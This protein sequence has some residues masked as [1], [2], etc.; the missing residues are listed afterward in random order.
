MRQPFLFSSKNFNN[1][2]SN[3]VGIILKSLPNKPKE[4]NINPKYTKNEDA[5]KKYYI[6]CNLYSGCIN[7]LFAQK[8]FLTPHWRHPDTAIHKG[9]SAGTL[10]SSLKSLHFLQ[11]IRNNKNQ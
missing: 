8:Y 6:K 2:Y 3:L 11:L 1:P 4:K 7:T 5:E 10:G 9:Q